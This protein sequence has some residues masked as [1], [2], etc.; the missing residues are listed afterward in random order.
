MTQCKNFIVGPS[1]FSWWG[2]WLSNKND[3]ICI[4][5]KYLN[6]SNNKD[7]WPQDWISI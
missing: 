3:K 5:P 2:A 1:T 7:F 6:P 4:R